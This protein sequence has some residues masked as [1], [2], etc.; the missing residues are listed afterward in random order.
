MK[1]GRNKPCHCGSGKKYKHCHEMSKKSNNNQY[2]IIGLAA[3][4][5]A[6]VL[7]ISTD[8]NESNKRTAITTSPLRNQ[9]AL[10]SNA[11]PDGIA[12][13]GKVWHEGHGHWHDAPL[14]SST[15]KKTSFNPNNS[16]ARKSRPKRDAPPG[17]VWHEGHG[18]WH[19]APDKRSITPRKV[20][21]SEMEKPPLP[22]SGNK[23]NTPNGKVWDADHEHFHDKQ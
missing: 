18:H 23:N 21:D 10:Q 6:V 16:L 15:P 19:D 12:P 2:I 7:F 8:R 4:V 20:G 11:R 1:I 22:P 17:K 9:R 13:P 5:I 14:S 3:A